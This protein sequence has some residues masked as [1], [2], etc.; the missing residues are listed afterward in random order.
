MAAVDDVIEA[1]SQAQD[2]AG[3]LQQRYE[4][5]IGET[6]TALEK[7]IAVGDQSTID[8]FASVKDALEKVQE[9]VHALRSAT[10]DVISRLGAIKGS[11]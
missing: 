8:G 1:V 11:T 7:S 9:Q 3:E 6:D 5:A 4:Q 10:D 2:T